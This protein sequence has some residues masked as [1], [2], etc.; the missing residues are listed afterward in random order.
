MLAV[1]HFVINI[2]LQRTPD[3]K[4]SSALFAVSQSATVLSTTRLIIHPK[5]YQSFVVCGG[6]PK[7]LIEMFPMGGWWGLFECWYCLAGVRTKAKKTTLMIL[8]LVLSKATLHP[9]PNSLLF[10]THNQQP[11][12]SSLCGRFV[13]NGTV[14]TRILAYVQ[15]LL[16]LIS[17][18][19]QGG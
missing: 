11:R 10:T 8:L 2:R 7:V 6:L 12:E 18:L 19:L 3:R 14:C 16:F 17:R 15:H 1:S 4:W 9:I 13:I 5:N